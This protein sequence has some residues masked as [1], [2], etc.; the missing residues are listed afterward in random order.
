MIF[1]KNANI[2]KNKDYSKLI[3]VK[4]MTRQG[5]ILTVYISPEQ[6]NSYYTRKRVRQALKQ[7]KQEVKH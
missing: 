5:H 7:I 3:P 4:I 6:L 2:K 1:N